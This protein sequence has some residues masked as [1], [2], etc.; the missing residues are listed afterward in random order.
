MTR[1]LRKHQNT[2]R[3]PKPNHCRFDPGNQTT[4]NEI[5]KAAAA[6]GKKGGA[7]KSDAKLAAC[8]ENAKKAGRKPHRFFI[9]HRTG[10]IYSTMA[11]LRADALRECRF[12][13]KFDE[14]GSTTIQAGFVTLQ[15]CLD[16]FHKLHQT[17]PVASL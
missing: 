17:T 16:E 3:S 5:S 11:G 1:D 8:R 7:S 4:M 14:Q 12:R 9:L 10:G 13:N 6:M 15:E 2:S